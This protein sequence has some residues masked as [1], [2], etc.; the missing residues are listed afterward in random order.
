MFSS[1]NFASQLLDWSNINP[2]S[3]PWLA[4]KNIYKIWIAE[5][6]LQQT[7]VDQVI[8]Y[9]SKFLNRFPNVRSLA[10]AD[11]D[12]VLKLWEGLGYY[13]RAR[14]MTICAKE[15]IQLHGGKFPTNP[16]ELKKLRGIG[17]YTSAAISSFASDYPIVAV[18][19]NAIRVLSRIFGL[20]Y[21]PYSS[22]GKK[23][24]QKFANKCLG[25][26]TSSIFNQALMDFGSSIC[27]PKNPK[28]D[29]C[30]FIEECFAYKEIRISDF[31]PKKQKIIKTKRTF[32]YF[33]MIDPKGRCLIAK[34]SSNDIW[35]GLYE[36][37]LIENK[38]TSAFTKLRIMQAVKDI[39]PN[40][41]EPKIES[42][43]KFKHLLTHQI[44]TIFFYKV[45]VTNALR[46][47]NKYGYLVESVENF[48]NFAFPRIVRVF[49]D[50][51][52]I[53]N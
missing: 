30:P 45:Q 12:Q 2:R 37:A 23:D 13:S 7:R 9:Y 47:K 21:N 34:R 5:I 27:I 20:D 52:I 18:D 50:D 8:P 1:K 25:K 39:L 3:L 15:I 16:E 44:L 53:K 35:E 24:Y 29:L 11:L 4:E 31:P 17:D 46:T 43:S 42:V 33:M 40:E 6:M 36:F 51:Q 26:S 22:Q 41:L 48:L 32:N 49:L 14:N 19:G 28:C 10:T 38:S